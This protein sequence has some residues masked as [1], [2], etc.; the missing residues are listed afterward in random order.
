MQPKSTYITP[1][2]YLALDREADIKYQYCAGEIFAMGGASEEHNLIVTNLIRELSLQLKERPCKVYPSDMRVKVNPT[3]LYT[4]PDVTVVCGEAR[5]D[6]E[7]FDTLLNPTILFEVLSE[8]TSDY[9]RGGKFGH[10]RKLASLQEY[11]LVDQERV[12]AEHH[13]RQPD[14]RWLLAETDDA[15]DTIFLE[16]IDCQLALTDVYHKIT[17]DAASP[18]R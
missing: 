17:L 12:Y 14:N 16:S 2:A 13:T 9:D 7:K 18:P 11:V 15:N 10:Y 5:F 3:G 1:E 6:D 4:Y 8:S